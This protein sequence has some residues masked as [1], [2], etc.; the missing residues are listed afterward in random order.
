MGSV[1]GEGN[2]CRLEEGRVCGA[3]GW[4]AGLQCVA[5]GRRRH[6]SSANC[7]LGGEAQR[8]DQG[9][10]PEIGAIPSEDARAGEGEANEAG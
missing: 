6:K 2:F 10:D 1:R 5:P 8:A 9:A 7:S 3:L 4:P